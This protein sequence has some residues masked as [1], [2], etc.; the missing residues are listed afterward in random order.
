[1][2]DVEFV[3]QSAA[4]RVKV[5]QAEVDEL[6]Q[7]A[8]AHLPELL[9]RDSRALADT[10][11]AGDDP[12]LGPLLRFH[13]LAEQLFHR[14][15]LSS[16]RHAKNLENFRFAQKLSVVTALGI[17][18]DQAI[19]GMRRVNAL[20]NRCAHV[21]AHRIDVLDLDRIGECMG[22]AYHQFKALHGDDLKVLTIWTLS[23]LYEPFLTAVL[24]AEIVSRA[25]AE[26]GE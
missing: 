6:A 19:E 9:D 21:H 12:A 18:P 25:K 22:S 17:V 15:F 11:T 13:L 20:R 5:D 26:A 2:S 10:L 14:L 23:K 24:T 16:F 4:M 8:L 7:K 1:V 3:G